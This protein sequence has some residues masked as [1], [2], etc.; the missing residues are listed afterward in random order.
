MNS[1][2]LERVRRL[3]LLLLGRRRH[4]VGRR[5]SHLSVEAEGRRH[6][7]EGVREMLGSVLVVLRV[8]GRR[9]RGGRRG[10]GR[11]GRV[12]ERA[13]SSVSTVGEE[14]VLGREGRDE[15]E[16]ESSQNDARREE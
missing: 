1:L 15:L 4:D 5:R 16:S 7:V 14:P 13:L 3:L 12:E 11:L 2:P 10:K 8:H 9:R 6:L